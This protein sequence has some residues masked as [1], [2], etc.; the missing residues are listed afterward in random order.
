MLGPHSTHEAVCQPC[1]ANTSGIHMLDLP[2][3]CKML[4]SKH[5]LLYSCN[6]LCRNFQ[7]PSWFG[8]T[9]GMY[10]EQRIFCN[11]LTSVN[12]QAGPNALG[13]AINKELELICSH[14]TLAKISSLSLRSI[15]LAP[16][17]RR[18]SFVIVLRMHS[19]SGVILRCSMIVC[20]QCFSSISL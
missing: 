5:L 15:F 4:V 7:Y 6:P 13:N 12:N 8:Q 3:G 20:S 2:V 17:R 1:R 18:K 10:V 9:I 14:S 19:S 11:Q 16:S